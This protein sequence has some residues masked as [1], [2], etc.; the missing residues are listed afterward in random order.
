MPLSVLHI[1]VQ[2]EFL[3]YVLKA[4]GIE[5]D[6]KGFLNNLEY[7]PNASNVMPDCWGFK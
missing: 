2:S 5:K 3:Q 4:V 7:A 6:N 1:F